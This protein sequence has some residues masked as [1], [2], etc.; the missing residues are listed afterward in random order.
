MD[1]LKSRPQDKIRYA[2]I[3]LVEMPVKENR[4]EAVGGGES[5][6]T[7]CKPDPVREAG[8]KEAWVRRV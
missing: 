5:H 1:F 8:R 4:E 7:A 6:Q 3:L 2:S